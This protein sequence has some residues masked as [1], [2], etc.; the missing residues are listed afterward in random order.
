MS[1]T[2]VGYVFDGMGRVSAPK[3]TVPV[4][5][6]FPKNPGPYPRFYYSTDTSDSA[7]GFGWE[8]SL[9]FDR[10]WEGDPH[11]GYSP[12]FVGQFKDFIDFPASSPHWFAFPTP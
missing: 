4:Y 6:Y 2:P 1:G 8:L 5:A 3:G 10:P 9:R 7:D 12:T 11:G